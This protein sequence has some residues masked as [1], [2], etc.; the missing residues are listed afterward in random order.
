MLVVDLTSF[1]P[2]SGNSQI[3]INGVEQ[4]NVI[5]VSIYDS[6]MRKVQESN[7]LIV[8]LNGL[9]KGVYIVGIQ[10]EDTTYSLKLILQ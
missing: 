3:T 7:K 9:T 10:T 4:T 6:A 8:D 5:A 1:C 2:I